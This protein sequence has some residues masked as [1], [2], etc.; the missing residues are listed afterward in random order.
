MRPAVLFLALGLA[1]AAAAPASA[2]QSPF[3]PAI[4]VNDR[5]V[6]YYEIQQRIR[7]FE[8]LNA[9]GDLVE[10]ARETLVNE[11]LQSDA[12]ERL[13]VA[14]TPEEIEDGMAEFA[15]RASLEPEQFIQAI[16]AEGISAQTF[17][18]FVEAGVTWRN[19]LRA[20]FGARAQV[21]EEEIDRA[22]ALSA[23]EGAARI[24]LA[25]IIIPIDPANPE[26]A[27]TRIQQLSETLDGD[28]GGFAS[29]ARR[30]SAAQT[31]PAGG[32]LGWRPLSSIPPQLRSLVLVL[33]PGDVTEPVPLG[34]ALAIF[35]L[36]DFEETGFVSPTVT[37]VDYVTAMIP[38]A[39]TAAATAAAESLRNEIDTCDDLYG[40]RPGGFER[41]SQLIEEVPQD[42]SVELMRLDDNEVSTALTRNGGRDMVFLMLCG[43]TTELPEG[44]RE[45]VRQALFTQRL[46]SYADGFL[47]ELRA[48]AIITE[49]E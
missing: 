46:E 36:R 23:T 6:T 38:G 43:R 17:R 44:G 42:I 31:A 48:D 14:A 35:Q 39:G 45:E 11:R 32:A 1:A 4:T 2:Q 49:D 30:F 3:T 16:E 25:E 12:G 13:G 33:G 21:S 28:I 24:R 9:P 47:E 5:I 29:A 26:A 15:A 22:L 37:A 27:R 10:R 34:P 20:R 19:V 8:V 41:V 40:V 18:D 7:F